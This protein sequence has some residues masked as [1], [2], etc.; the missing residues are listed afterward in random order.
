M[1]PGD[2]APVLVA[3]IMTLVTG[4]VLIFRGP[5]GKALARRLEGNLG[6]A[7]EVEARINDLELRVAD[8]ERERAELAERIEFAERMLLQTKNAP[9]EI[10]R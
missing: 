2:F 4:A 6:P 7:P 1:P 10:G 3:T 8:S 9:R 5:L